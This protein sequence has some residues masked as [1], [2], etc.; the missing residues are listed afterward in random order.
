MIVCLPLALNLS[1]RDRNEDTPGRLD[2]DIQLMLIRGGSL[3]YKGQVPG[4][5]HQVLWK[6]PDGPLGAYL[7]LMDLLQR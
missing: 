4:I 5:Q 7:K 1:C 6:F 3:A 2:S